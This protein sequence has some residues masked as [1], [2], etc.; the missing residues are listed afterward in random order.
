MQTRIYPCSVSV[1]AAVSIAKNG[2]LANQDCWLLNQHISQVSARECHGSEKSRHFWELAGVFDGIGSG[3]GSELA[4]RIAAEE[5][6]KVC[7]RLDSSKAPAFLDQ[8]M[9]SAF[10]RANNQILRAAPKALGTTGTVVCWNRSVF[11]LYYL[12]DSRAY[13]L[14][15]GEL[16]CLTE[17][18]TV[19]RLKA[20][21]RLPVNPEDKHTLAD[22]I[23]KDKN[24]KYLTPSR[25][26]WISIMP[27]DLLLLCSDGLY[28]SLT[29]S[30]MRVSIESGFSLEEKAECLSLFAQE[31]G[32]MDD[33]TCV[34]VQLSS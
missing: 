9:D 15:N 27:G 13:L 1:G 33:I 24:G 6:Q 16:Y 31:N 5:F 21:T 12:G 8:C 3:Q 30:Q 10:L 29:T 19:A 26:A 18:H 25:S 34:L 14:R 2:S 32:N 11:R 22:Y 28:N 7:S 4:S 20:R 23:G 17:D